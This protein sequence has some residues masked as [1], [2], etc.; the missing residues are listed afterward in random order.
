[1]SAA[2][3]LVR[4][5]LA[6]ED[7]QK[8]T[9]YLNTAYPRSYR[10]WFEALYKDKYTYLGDAELMH[11]AFLMDLATYFLGPVRG[12]YN[13]PSVEW[14]AHALRRPVAAPFFGAF[15]AFY[16]RRLVCLAQERVRKGIYGRK[17]HG[18]MSSSR[19]S[20]CRPDTSAFRLLLGRHQS[21]AESRDHDL[22]GADTERRTGDDG[23]EEA[24]GGVKLTPPRK[25][26]LRRC[27]T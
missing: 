25:T 7:T 11:A 16:N 3:E 8:I 6:G 27:S 18:H 17:N 4:K 24:G 2:T 14:I 9:E 20:A 5:N 23:G 10:T 13:N 26:S 22:A 15:M 19:A 1:V 12:V 21:L